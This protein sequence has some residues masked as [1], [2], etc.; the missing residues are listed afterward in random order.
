MDRDA[1]EDLRHRHDQAAGH[2]D[3][4]RGAASAGR[5][6]D[7]RQ[8]IVGHQ[9]QLVDGRVGLLERGARLGVEQDVLL[10]GQGLVSAGDR[11]G[12]VDGAPAGGP[13]VGHEHDRLGSVLQHRSHLHVVGSV[14]GHVPRDADGHHEMDVR[15]RVTE[16]IA[17]RD[18]GLG[19]GAVGAGVRVE[20]VQTVRAGAEVVPRCLRGT[21]PGH[22][23][24]C[25]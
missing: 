8:A 25:T 16:P 18:V 24:G 7:H 21:W 13:V 6:L 14:I 10:L 11:R 9:Q 4:C 22:R 2:G 3:R 20:V 23:R 12:H 19:K 1:A 17:G 15:Q 5:E